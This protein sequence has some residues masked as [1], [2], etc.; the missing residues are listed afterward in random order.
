MA[1]EV[2]LEPAPVTLR[3]ARKTLPGDAG[4]AGLAS[5]VAEAEA[6]LT[7]YS[8]ENERLQGQNSELRQRRQFV[9]QDYTGAPLAFA[10]AVQQGSGLQERGAEQP[11]RQPDFAQRLSS[12]STVAAGW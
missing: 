2:Q 7:K 1:A 8:K 4:V 10:L 11:C 9:D 3:T 5:R 6:L 12:C